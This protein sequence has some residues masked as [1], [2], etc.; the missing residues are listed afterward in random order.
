M[1]IRSG[2]KGGPLMNP[3]ARIQ[4]DTTMTPQEALDY[5]NGARF[6]NYSGQ[7]I[8]AARWARPVYCVRDRLQ[9]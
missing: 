3:L 1:D 8:G 6:E 7:I 9:L 5:I 4:K 2:Y